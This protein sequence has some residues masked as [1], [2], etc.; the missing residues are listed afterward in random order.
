MNIMVFKEES[1]IATIRELAKSHF[2]R[3]VEQRED[4]DEAYDLAD[5]MYKCGTHRGMY[6]KERRAWVPRYVEGKANVGS[7]LLH[8]QVNTLAGM[9]GGILL[10][11]RDLWRYADKPVAGNP[12]SG[13]TGAMKADQM[14]ALAKWIQKADNF[15]KKLPE[16]CVSIFKYSNI[17]AHISMRREE[18][19]V[20]ES[21][22][23][24]EVDGFDENGNPIY[25]WKSRLKKRKGV[26]YEYPTIVFPHPR[27]VYA[28]K[29][30][31]DI[32]GQECVIVLSQT[33]IT[34]L[35]QEGRWLDQEAIAGLDMEKVAWDETY[36]SEA[37][38]T[39]EEHLG[40][41]SNAASGVILRWDV[42]IWLPVK[43]GHV[44]D[45]ASRK[46][47]EKD[48]PYQ[49]KL[50]W[51]VFVG[52]R[53]DEAVLLKCTDEF[54]PDGEIPIKE[55]RAVPD[56]SD[57]LYHTFISEVVRP[58]Y[59][60][61]CAS[62]NAAIDRDALVN[63]PPRTVL[64]GKHGIKD[65]SWKSGQVWSVERHDT[66]NLFPVPQTQLATLALRDQIRQDIKLALA[67][68]DAKMGEYAGSRT[69][70]FE[71]L[72]VTS[73]TD[74][75][76][77]LRNAYIVGQI[78]PWI[79]RKYVS[80]CSE[81]MPPEV[82]QRVLNEMMFPEPRG[83]IIGSYDIVVDIVG[84]YEEDAT[85]GLGLDRMMQILSNP[86][87]IASD[88]HK[89][90]VGELVKM[91]IEHKKLPVTKLVGP[92]SM[93]DAESNARQRIQTMLITGVYIPPVPGENAEIH[94]R[95]AQAER[96][97]WR[98]LEST[99]DS[100]AVNVGLIDQYIADV[101]QLV[102]QQ[103]ATAQQEILGQMTPGQE[104]A[105]PIAATLGA[106]M[107]GLQ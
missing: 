71:V 73:A 94:L 93:P 102:G 16:F 42:Y 37:R 105:A 72:R 98:M 96:L 80:Y 23:T 78:L 74:A 27:C 43:H 106:M 76:I 51:C 2:D 11:G 107:G 89:I 81:F 35:M 56:D 60:A 4:I 62:M 61:D 39:E 54:D 38:R 24:Q 82:R 18:R 85:R 59:A 47:D 69:S 25:K 40:R 77:S 14:N 49:M 19:E 64:I 50:Y 46:E 87:F 100:R 6:N 10:S 41:K 88:T 21:E 99:G 29:Y 57:M 92:P 31:K 5:W 91:Y 32:A 9:L 1:D 104:A 79:A 26:K 3:F 52:N 33:T 86:A 12:M 15:D 58:M 17:F 75:T 83:E 101:K 28:D 103:R 63:D 67:T 34:K 53:L 36:G 20:L 7:T 44:I 45:L 68:D 55:I 65:F 30:I 66:V 95:I 70:A 97:R 84:Q 8:R 48:D 90:Y 22:M 13:E